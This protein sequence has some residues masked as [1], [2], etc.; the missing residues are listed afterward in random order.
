MPYIYG[1]YYRRMGKYSSTNHVLRAMALRFMYKILRFE[2]ETSLV[3][4][5]ANVVIYNKTLIRLDQYC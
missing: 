2:K 3:C 1:Q 5:Q 4:T